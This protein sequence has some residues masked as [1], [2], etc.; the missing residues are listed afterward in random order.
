MNFY[1]HQ[2]NNV[3]LDNKKDNDSKTSTLIS[4]I[5]SVTVVFGV[6]EGGGP[7]KIISQQNKNFL[8]WLYT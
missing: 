3:L 1:N 5:L 7:A 6:G 2:N 8:Q 4:V